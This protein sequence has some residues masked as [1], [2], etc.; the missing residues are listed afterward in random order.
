MVVDAVLCIIHMVAAVYIVQKIQQEHVLSP[1]LI[2]AETGVGGGKEGS[3]T[4]PGYQAMPVLSTEGKSG[5]ERLK[6]VLCYDVGVALY[7]VAAIVWLVWLTVGFQQTVADQDDCG[8]HI[9]FSILCG[10]CYATVVGCA[11]GCSLLCLR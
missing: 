6:D 2:D 3:P 1:A 8:S 9:I 10:Y 7:I 4:N 5:A 11:F